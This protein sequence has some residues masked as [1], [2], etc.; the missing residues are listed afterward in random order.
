MPAKSTLEIGKA[1]G[2]ILEF[3]T[4]F[5]KTCQSKNMFT[6]VFV[7]PKTKAILSLVLLPSA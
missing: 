1:G 6:N 5:T 4:R 7:P 2:R 3:R